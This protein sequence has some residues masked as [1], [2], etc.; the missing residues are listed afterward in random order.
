MTFGAETPTQVIENCGFTKPEDDC[1]LGAT[2]VGAMYRWAAMRKVLPGVNNRLEGAGAVS[3]SSSQCE[4]VEVESDYEPEPWCTME[5]YHCSDV[6]DIPAE[7]RMRGLD[8]H[9]LTRTSCLSMGSRRASTGGIASSA[10][11]CS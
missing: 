5:D 1:K 3:S 6:F 11:T 9:E 8:E 2:R 10:R 7:A 4:W